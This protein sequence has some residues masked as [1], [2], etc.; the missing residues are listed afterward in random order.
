[1]LKGLTILHC[2]KNVHTTGVDK[3]IQHINRSTGETLTKKYNM[4]I[5]QVV[6]LQTHSL[7]LKPKPEKGEVNNNMVQGH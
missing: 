2:P 3:I 5:G 1:M 4:A 6:K 7:A